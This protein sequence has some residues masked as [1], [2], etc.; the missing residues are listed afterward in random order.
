[1][2]KNLLFEFGGNYFVSVNADNPI[3]G[4][5]IYRKAFLFAIPIEF[6]PDNFAAVSLA[7]LY[8]AVGAAGINDNNLVTPAYRAEGPLDI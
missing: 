8:R 5:L 2:R 6:A 3:M 1:V 7:N 4:S